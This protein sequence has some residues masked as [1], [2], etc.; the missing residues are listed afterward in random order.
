[1]QSKSELDNY[2]ALLKKHDWYYNY[3]DDHSVWRRGRDSYAELCKQQ[4]KLDPTKEIWN[5]YVKS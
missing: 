5:K 1:M 3:S 2:E 4:V